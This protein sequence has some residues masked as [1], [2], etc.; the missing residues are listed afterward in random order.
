MLMRVSRLRCGLSVKSLSDGE[1]CFSMREICRGFVG[2]TA[3]VLTLLCLTLLCAGCGLAGSETTVVES[4]RHVPA[5]LL[6]PIEMPSLVPPV[7]V[8]SLLVHCRAL[9]DG[10]LKANERFEEIRNLQERQ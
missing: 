8:R 9:E 2:M 6:T 1:A 4:R 5:Q 10:I 7:T 3:R